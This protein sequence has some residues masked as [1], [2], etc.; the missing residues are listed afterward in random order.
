MMWISTIDPQGK[1]V[2]RKILNNVHRKVQGIMVSVLH[3]G[4]I[5]VGIY[6][7]LL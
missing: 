5:N 4:I 3:R 6:K 2:R 1:T 7:G